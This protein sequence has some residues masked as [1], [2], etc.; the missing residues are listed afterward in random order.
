MKFLLDTH[1]LVWLVG[2]S[3]SLSVVARSLLKGAQEL[4]VSSISLWEI[5]IK[6]SLGK[7][8]VDQARLDAEIEQIGARPLAVT[9]AH[10]RAV[11]ALPLIHN[12]PFDRMLVAQAMSEPLH[13]MTHDAALRAY[14]DLVVVV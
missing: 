9:A 4:Q 10:A 14:S 2:D 11:R 5:A 7:M 13:F 1:I 6:A 3:P 12:D 8:R